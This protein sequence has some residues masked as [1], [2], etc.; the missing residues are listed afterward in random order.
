MFSWIKHYM[1][2]LGALL[3]ALPVHK[4]F[5]S[6]S[7]YFVEATLAAITALSLLGN[8]CISLA[9]LDLGILSHS[10][11]QLCSSCVKLDWD[12]W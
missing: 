8:V 4:V 11:L 3:S 2:E 1:A 9:H 6:L 12:C 5:S 10:S 7:Q